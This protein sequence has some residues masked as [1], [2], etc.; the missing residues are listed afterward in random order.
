MKIK[1]IIFKRELPKNSKKLEFKVPLH[2]CAI[3]FSNNYLNKY[4]NA[5]YNETFL[6][7]EEEFL[8]QRVLKDNLISI[9]SPKI[10]VFHKEGASVKKSSG[11]EIESKLFC[12]KEKLKSLVLLERELYLIKGGKNG[13]KN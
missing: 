7:H 10:K 9:Y 2:G 5:F 13:S 4:L 6:F 12:E 1:S 11:H 8:Y 3:I